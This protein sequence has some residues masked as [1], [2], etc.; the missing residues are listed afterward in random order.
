[1]IR[2]QPR[3][4]DGVAEPRLR[5]LDPVRAS[6]RLLPAARLPCSRCQ[7]GARQIWHPYYYFFFFFFR[8]QQPHVLM[9]NPCGAVWKITAPHYFAIN[10]Y[11]SG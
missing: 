8:L 3:A 11:E 9:S 4:S 7:G 10:R 6:E 5:S 2:L 1:M